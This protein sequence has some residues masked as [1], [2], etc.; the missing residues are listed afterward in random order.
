MPDPTNKS[1]ALILRPVEWLFKN[2]SNFD[3][4]KNL[5]FYYRTILTLT[6]NEAWIAFSAKVG[7]ELQLI[8]KG[9]GEMN[10][11]RLRKL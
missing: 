10:T 8:R 7:D 11:Y 2:H 1:A 5:A 9:W 3:A 6:Q 4:G